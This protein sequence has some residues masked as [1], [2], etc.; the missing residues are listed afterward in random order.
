MRSSEC[1]GLEEDKVK[2][3]TTA[4]FSA[5]LTKGNGSGKMENKGTLGLLIKRVKYRFQKKTVFSSLLC[6]CNG[7]VA[8]KGRYLSGQAKER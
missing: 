1:T 3:R 2:A 4:R 8:S 7:R 5:E 6:M